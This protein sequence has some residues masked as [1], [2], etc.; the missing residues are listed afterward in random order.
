MK[1]QYIAAAA[2][3]ALTVTA[4]ANTPNFSAITIRETGNFLQTLP[5]DFHMV[6]PAAA[7]SQI[8]AIK[9]FLLDVREPNEFADGRLPGAVNVPL[10]TL[11]AKLSE[12]PDKN[13]PIIV[14]CGIGHRGALALPFLK[15]QGYTNIRSM[16][17]GY[18]A[19]VA[20]SYP[21]EK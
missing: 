19:W 5:T 11:P 15:M 16:A 3:A 9:P 10:R 14:Y 8:D 13:R 7:K 17:G 1:K 2:L 12:L 6:Q 20:A 21:T 4:F 18:K